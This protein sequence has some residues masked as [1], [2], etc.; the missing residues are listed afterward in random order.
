[1]VPEDAPARERRDDLGDGTDEREEHDVD[2][3]VAVEPEQVLVRGRAARRRED[4]DAAT[5]ELEQRER[6]EQHRERGERHQ[7]SHEHRP[8]EDR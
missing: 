2:N 8:A 7:R 6:D 4:A 5:V 3:G 1:V